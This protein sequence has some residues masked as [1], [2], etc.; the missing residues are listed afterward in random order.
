MVKISPFPDLL[1]LLKKITGSVN[2]PVTADIESGYANTNAELQKNI[3]LLI[4][5]GI[6]GIN[7]E[8]SDKKNNTLLPLEIQCERIDLIKKVAVKTGIPLFINARTDVYHQRKR[9]CE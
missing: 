3:E 6:V 1:T 9:F 7:I 8:D 4:E 5:A 2:I